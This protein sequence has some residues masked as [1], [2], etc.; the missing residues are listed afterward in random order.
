MAVSKPRRGTMV[1][2]PTACTAFGYCAELLPERIELDDWGFPIVNSE[3]I[4]D[5]H[6]YG[7]ARRAVA[8]C[9]RVALSL[10]DVDPALQAPDRR[11]RSRLR[12]SRQ[13]GAG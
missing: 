10:V 13:E 11:L 1:V 3:A 5:Q 6:L 9:P 12:S 8:T 4:E 2:D 7:L